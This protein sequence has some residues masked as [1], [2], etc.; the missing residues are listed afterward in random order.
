MRPRQGANHRPQDELLE[1]LSRSELEGDMAMGGKAEE[2]EDGRVAV[3]PHLIAEG[4]AE[5]EEDGDGCPG[6]V[7]RPVG[8]SHDQWCIAPSSDVISVI[9]I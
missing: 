2:A 5:R 9:G 8:P 1:G 7:M 3:G 6:L 4:T